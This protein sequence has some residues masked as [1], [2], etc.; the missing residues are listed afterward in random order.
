MNSQRRRYNSAINAAHERHAKKLRPFLNKA[1]RKL[2]ELEKGN[3]KEFQAEMDELNRIWR[4]YCR[5]YNAANKKID[6]ANADAFQLS[7]AN[8]I[9]SLKPSDQN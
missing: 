4:K 9:K 1:E 7:L 6:H 8:Y 2:D 5:R 3:L